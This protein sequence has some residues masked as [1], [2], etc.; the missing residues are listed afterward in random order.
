MRQ[1]V[2]RQAQPR[3]W[4]DVFTAGV[5]HGRRPWSSAD[6]RLDGRACTVGIEIGDEFRDQND[7]HQHRRCHVL[8]TCQRDDGRDGDEDFRPNLVLMD[9]VL[10]TSPEER[11]QANNDG[12]EEHP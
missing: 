2:Y 10:K 8:A 11:I 5:A 9:Q 7:R 6:E 4:Y 1:V 3:R 12:D